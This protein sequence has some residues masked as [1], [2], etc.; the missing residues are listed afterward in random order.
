V[1]GEA[2]FGEEKWDK[3]GNKKLVVGN[4]GEDPAGP[5]HIQYIYI[6]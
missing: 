2:R 5:H 3:K 4:P 1:R 6:I